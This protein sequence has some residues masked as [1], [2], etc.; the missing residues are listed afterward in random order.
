M[1]HKYILENQFL[2][3]EQWNWT[4]SIRNTKFLDHRVNNGLLQKKSKQGVGDGY[5]ISRGIEKKE[6]GNCR[7]QWNK[8]NFSGIAQWLLKIW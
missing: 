3:Q 8:W 7:G 5:V 4:K 1:S 6:F 2:T